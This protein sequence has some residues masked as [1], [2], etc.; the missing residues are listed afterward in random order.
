MPEPLNIDV[1]G[2]EAALAAA[3]VPEDLSTPV[4]GVAEQPREP[5]GQWTN[6]PAEAPTNTDVTDETAPAG[7]NSTETAPEDLFTQIDESSLTPEMQQLRKS[8][9]AD[10][11]RKMQEIAPLRKLGDEFGFESPE[12]FRVAAEVYSRLN[13]PKN[14]PTIH[15]ELSSYMEQYGM[16]PAAASRQAANLMA[17][18]TPADDLDEGYD[19]EGFEVADPS[20]APAFRALQQQVQQLSQQLTQREENDRAQELWNATAQK[21]TD[22]ENKIRAE[23]KHYGDDEISDIYN[24]LGPEGDLVAAQQR[25]E[26]MIGRRLSQYIGTKAAAQAG[27]PAAL[28]GAGTQTQ[29]TADDALEGM[30]ADQVREVMHRRAMAHV[31][32]LDRQG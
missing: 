14:W 18:A 32:E 15:Q 7:D 19:D 24:L 27:T 9:Q 16:S 13:D 8:L 6:K 31:A 20:T 23:N 26:S 12:D 10:Y 28:P 11:T 5:N 25:Y 17:E 22:A 30:T 29:R 4:P 21:L 2:A 3:G 1:A